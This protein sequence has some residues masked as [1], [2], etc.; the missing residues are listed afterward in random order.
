MAAAFKGEG[1]LCAFRTAGPGERESPASSGSSGQ[2]NAAG[3]P[4]GSRFCRRFGIPGRESKSG[5]V[6]WEP[7]LKGLVP[8]AGSRSGCSDCRSP[9]AGVRKWM[10][11]A[12]LALF[13]AGGQTLD[14]S[15]IPVSMKLVL[16]PGL[17]AGNGGQPR[18]YIKEEGALRELPEM[19]IGCSGTVCPSP[20]PLL[21]RAG[22]LPES[23]P[24]Y[25]AERGA[26]TEGERLSQGLDEPLSGKCFPSR[27]FLTQRGANDF[28]LHRLRPGVSPHEESAARAPLQGCPSPGVCGSLPAAH[29]WRI[30]PLFPL[31]RPVL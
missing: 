31:S 22:P 29:L 10:D 27:A 5:K 1:F 13:P 3:K 15:R 21:L 28:F 9:A 12:S 20:L 8:A 14:F 17:P 23:M 11:A 25:A 24:S 19:R 16:G 30:S 26:V 4:G 7:G 2:G 18:F 6:R